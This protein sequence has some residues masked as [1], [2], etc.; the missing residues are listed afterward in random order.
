MSNEAIIINDLSM[1]FN[2]SREKIDNAKE[3]AI[4]KLKKQIQF[5]EFYALR[6]VSFTVK[7]GDAFAIIGENGCGKSTLLK[8]ISGIYYPTTGSVSVEGTISPLIELGAGFDMDLTAKENIYLNGAVLGRSK[9]FIDE[10][11]EEIMDFAELWDFVNVPLKNFSSGMIARLGFSIATT[12]VP[13][14]LIVDE[15]LAVGDINFQK[16]CEEKMEKMLSGGT[17]LLFVSHDI[18]QVKKLCRHAVW[19]NKGVVQMVGDATEVADAYVKDMTENGG[20]GIVHIEDE[21]ATDASAQAPS[22]EQANASTAKKPPRKHYNFILWLHAFAALL[23]TYHHSIHVLFS[24]LGLQSRLINFV[25]AHIIAP[26]GLDLG[27]LGVVI[28]FAVSGFL[29]T[30]SLQ[31]YSSVKY[32]WKKATRIFLPLFLALGGLWGFSRLLTI[33]QGWPAYWEQFT[34]IEWIQAGTL[35]GHFTGASE[36]IIGITWFLVALMMYYILS[37]ILRPVLKASPAG[38]TA[39]ILAVIAIFTFG[40][41]YLGGTWFLIASYLQ[42]I[43]LILFGQIL[44]M[45]AQKI[46]TMKQ[47]ALLAIANFILLMQN[48]RLFFPTLYN[49]VE[50]IKSASIIIGL[51]IFAIAFVCNDILSANPIAK[52]VDKTSYALYLSHYQIAQLFVPVLFVALGYNTTLTMGAIVLFMIIVA[53]LETA[54]IDLIYKIFDLISKLFKCIKRRPAK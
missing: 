22:D 15:I 20:R 54:I 28:F 38:F 48:L 8:A 42:H 7:K 36:K 18:N 24:Q 6:N 4:K 44:F 53:I 3:D 29:N 13:D 26:F 41:S 37:A 23:I 16:K 25:N 19:L 31:R 33:M 17:T 27:Y 46:L 43:P 50:G 34:L 10:H 14:I 51:A 39:S 40:L 47:A 5:D 1:R 35:V 9:E 11:F 12:T 30:E 21:A 52:F 32:L 49:G 45:S 2:L